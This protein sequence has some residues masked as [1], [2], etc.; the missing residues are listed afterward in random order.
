VT[1]LLSRDA[2]DAGDY[3]DRLRVSDHTLVE[4][5]QHLLTPAARRL[6]ELW[7]DDACSFS[8]VTIAIARIRHMFVATAPLFP[9]HESRSQGDK[10]SILMTAVPG[11]QHTFGLYLVIEHFRAHDWTVW[12]GT[13]RSGQEMIDLLGSEHCDVVGISVGSKRNLLSAA[14]TVRDIRKH[15][16]NKD[17]VVIAGGPLLFTEPELADTIAADLIIEEVNDNMIERTAKLVAQKR[18][19][20]T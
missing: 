16:A 17:V 8:D 9:V 19:L 13:P 11:E 18:A 10:P 2:D 1:A 14:K 12:S 5:Y 6:G 3:I 20:R 4:V 7:E 15:S